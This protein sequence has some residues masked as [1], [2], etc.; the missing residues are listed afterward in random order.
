M[1]PPAGYHAPRRV[2][3]VRPLGSRRRIERVIGGLISRFRKVFNL[4]LGQGPAAR[5]PVTIAPWLP[6][7]HD[8]LEDRSRIM[9]ETTAGPA[10]DEPGKGHPAPCP[11]AMTGNAFRT[12]FAAG[13]LMLA[14]ST[15]GIEYPGK[16]ELVDPQQTINSLSASPGHRQPAIAGAR[17]RATRAR[18]MASTAAS[19]ARSVLVWRGG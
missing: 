5:F 18:S 3:V 7:W 6:H 4:L 16:A 8:R 13:R 9:P 2:R 10:S 12:V 1:A 14:T 17:P 15:G 11:P 19:N